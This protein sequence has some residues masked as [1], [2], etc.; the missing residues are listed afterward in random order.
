M[1]LVNFVAMPEE[2][3][4]GG[5]IYVRVVVR[6]QNLSYA[7]RTHQYAVLYV[8]REASKES[9]YLSCSKTDIDFSYYF[10]NLEYFSC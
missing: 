1:F 2:T 8:E 7:T 10:L 3:G 5:G 9:N 6:A 4:G